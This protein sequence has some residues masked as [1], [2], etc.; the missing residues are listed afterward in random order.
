[1]DM[2]YSAG[3]RKLATHAGS[4]DGTGPRLRSGA[5]T[6]PRSN[7]SL[8]LFPLRPV[9]RTQSATVHLHLEVRAG[10]RRGRAQWR[11]SASANRLHGNGALTGPHT[12]RGA[13]RPSMPLGWISTCPL[14]FLQKTQAAAPTS[15]PAGGALLCFALLFPLLFRNTNAGSGGSDVRQA[16]LMQL[17]HKR[18]MQNAEAVLKARSL[19]GP[20][21]LNRAVQR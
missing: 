2:C 20:R 1:M 17:L 15:H 4:G 3:F 18:Y 11:R 6:V 14:C 21:H 16:R 19:F 7:T 10:P 9:L 12:W 8:G 13:I 5:V